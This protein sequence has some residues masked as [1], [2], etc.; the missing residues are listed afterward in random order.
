[1]PGPIYPDSINASLDDG[2]LRM[3]VPK[4]EQARPR[5]VVIQTPPGN[6]GPAEPAVTT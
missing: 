1:L 5:R 3:T 4:P 6:G 2:I